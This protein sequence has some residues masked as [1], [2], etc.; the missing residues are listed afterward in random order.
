MIPNSSCVPHYW[1][2]YIWGQ[3]NRNIGLKAF[4]NLF[5]TECFFQ[6]QINKKL[7]FFCKKEKSLFFEEEDL[8][9]CEAYQKKSV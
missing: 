3:P 2:I 1:E 8:F 9:N 5:Q 7:Q 4:V 6:I